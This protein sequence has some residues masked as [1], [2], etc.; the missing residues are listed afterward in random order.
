MTI[1]TIWNW[2]ATASNNTDIGG[3]SVAENGPADEINNAIRN[4]MSQ[5]A[6]FLS[7]AGYQGTVGGSANAIT[8]TTSAGIASLTTGRIVSL[9]AAYT[10]TNPAASLNVDGL[11]AK[12]IL[13]PIGSTMA[14]VGVGG[15]VA[16]AYYVFLYDETADSAAGAWLMIG[17][18]ATA[19]L[20]SNPAYEYN[21][22]LMNGD[23]QLNQRAFAG[24]SLSAGNY[25]YD[26]WK[27]GSGGASVIF[28]SG[29]ITLTSGS[30]VQVIESPDIAGET[31]TLSVED[32]TGSITVDIEGETYSIASGSGRQSV[33]LTIPSG[34]T[35]NIT[36]ELSA[37]SVTFSRI[38]L[39]IGSYPSKWKARPP[40]VE[41][42]LCQRYYCTVSTHARGYQQAG[43]SLV[44]MIFWPVEM[45]SNPS[46]T[47]TAGLTNNTSSDSIDSVNAR[48]ARHT[49]A[50]TASGTVSSLNGIVAADAEL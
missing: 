12:N 41:L 48:G 1:N 29:S 7:D 39:E 42:A 5:S 38:Q 21:N 26:R 22:L 33:T 20:G 36:V 3:Q 28:Y 43:Q 2:D 10:N 23:M 37:T 6:K 17:S 4:A 15:I 30:I 46:T 49:I 25:G 44:S 31:V 24:G 13:L 27:A 18:S 32:P 45:R 9:K 8:L 50:A 19:G 40:G 11:G 47:Y 34:S 14:N 16:G 35:G